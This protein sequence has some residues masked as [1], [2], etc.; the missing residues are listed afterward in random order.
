MH[1]IDN[2]INILLA[3]KAISQM[4]TFVKS[5]MTRAFSLINTKSSINELIAQYEEVKKE[6]F[7]TDVVK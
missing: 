6:G 4:K 1:K 7:P 3:E 2:Q 5:E